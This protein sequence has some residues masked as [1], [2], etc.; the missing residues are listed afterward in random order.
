VEAK[1]PIVV[2][3]Q[4][5]KEELPKAVAGLQTAKQKE[6]PAVLRR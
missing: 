6:N 3:N 4:M 1:L 5:R 2:S